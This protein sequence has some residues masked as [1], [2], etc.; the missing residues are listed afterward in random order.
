MPI[1]A[2]KVFLIN[3]YRSFCV[4]IHGGVI[5]VFRKTRETEEELEIMIQTDAAQELHS[6]IVDN[7][8]QIKLKEL[9]RQISNRIDNIAGFINTI[10]NM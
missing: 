5:I 4:S 6:L 10:I 8:V 1:E 2:K 9:M 3:E 7:E